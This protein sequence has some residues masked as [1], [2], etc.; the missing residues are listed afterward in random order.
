[1][2]KRVIIVYN[3]RSTGA[4][5]VEVGVL[6]PARRLK[7]K[8]VGKYAVLPT[9]VDDNAKKLAKLLEDG[10]LVIA[11][12]G[13]GTAT[14]AL[15][16]VVRA[17]KEVSLAVLPYGNFNDMAR[18]FNVKGFKQ[19]VRGET[20]EAWPLEV[21]VNGKIWRRVMCYVS[22]GMMAESTEVFDNA[23][24]RKGL[25]KGKKG[26][27]WSGINLFTWWCKNRKK[28]FLPEFS[29]NG[30]KVEKKVTDYLAV[31]SKT[32]AKVL[33]NKPSFRMSGS[34]YGGVLK[35]SGFL[36][37]CRFFVRG[38]NGKMGLFETEGDKI[39][40][41]KPA[42]VEIQAEGEYKKFEGVETIEIRKAAKPVR[43]VR[44]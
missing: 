33:K 9:D 41:K 28:R 26:L 16:G 13:D 20:I 7:G 32:V 25:Q 6:E 4:N 34:F 14:I 11:A 29:L 3:P 1:M 31:N 18:S 44:G 8:I 37:I 23:K 12:G 39:V 27:F 2:K 5:L 42:R 17:K 15:N 35:L 24:V 43:I 36:A 38:M 30:H 19:A 21:L 22:V 10:D 40:F